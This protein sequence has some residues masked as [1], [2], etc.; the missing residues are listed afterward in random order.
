MTVNVTNETTQQFEFSFNEIGEKVV[1]EVLAYEEF[2]FEVC[3]DITLVGLEEIHELNLLN[4]G[5]DRPTDVLS[6]PMVAY[7]CA[8]DYSRVEENDDNFDPDSGEVVLGD[9]V[10]CLDKV[11]QQAEEYG[12]SRLREYAFLVCHSMLHLLG[13]DHEFPEEETQMYSKQEEILDRL[14]IRREQ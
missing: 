2:P 12:H 11:S 10:I 8:G 3:V 9:I 5:V 1:R 6:F 13:Y 14:G 4:R 7:P